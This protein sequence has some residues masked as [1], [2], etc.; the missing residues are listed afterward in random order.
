MLVIQDW[1]VTQKVGVSGVVAFGQ[2]LRLPGFDL[3]LFPFVLDY[4]TGRLGSERSAT[5]D[6]VNLKT[7]RRYTLV[8]GSAQNDGRWP[9]TFFVDHGTGC[10]DLNF[11][12]S[13]LNDERYYEHSWHCMSFNTD[14][15]ELLRKYGGLPIDSVE[16]QLA[17]VSMLSQLE[18]QHQELEALMRKDLVVA[19]AQKVMELNRQLQM[20]NKAQRQLLEDQRKECEDE[21]KATSKKL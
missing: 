5:Y 6:L 9:A 19:R 7:G 20:E 13:Q 17:T 16:R 1:K 21:G 10:L 12:T 11:C 2:H 15:A 18:A 4:G 3:D 8:C 14:F